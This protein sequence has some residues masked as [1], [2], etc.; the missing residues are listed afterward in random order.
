MK[1]KYCYRPVWLK[2]NI[3]YT[4]VA[5]SVWNQHIV[6]K[7]TVLSMQKRGLIENTHPDRFNTPK[8]ALRGTMKDFYTDY[9]L[10]KKGGSL[11]EAAIKKDNNMTLDSRE[12]GLIDNL[13]QGKTP[14]SEAPLGFN[15]SKS[16]AENCENH[17]NIL[18]RSYMNQKEVYDSERVW[19]YRAIWHTG[20]TP[21]SEDMRNAALNNTYP[22]V[23]HSPQNSADLAADLE[24]P[25]YFDDLD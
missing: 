2:G 5:P 17:A 16:Y 7:V 23:P 22:S 15:S 12:Q 9:T 11:H 3:V 14:L 4:A 8:Q 25:N 18:A 21:S 20:N 10:S 1:K 24:M 13:V 19:D 6:N